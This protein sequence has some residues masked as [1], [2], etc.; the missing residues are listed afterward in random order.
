MEATADIQT[1]I[2]PSLGLTPAWTPFRSHAIQEAVWADQ[3]RFKVI[4]AGRGSGKTELAKR[5]LVQSLMFD[6][7]SK[8][9]PLR[10]YFYGAPTREHAKRVAWG[11]FIRLVPKSWLRSPD[12]ISRSEL[13]ITTRWGSKLWVLG[14]DKPERKVE[15]PQWHGCVLDESCD[16]KP[17][18]FVLNVMPAL[19]HHFG[20]CWRIGVPKRTGPSAVEYREYF[21]AACRGEKPGAKGYLW[22][23]SDI[24]SAEMLK[25]ARETLD[26][27]DYAEQFDAMFQTAGGGIYYCYDDVLNVRKCSYD[28]LLPIIVGSDFNVD[29][30]AWVI[31]QR[32]GDMLEWFDEIWLRDVSTP[33]AMDVLWA[34]WG[35]HKGGFQFFG[36]ASSSARKTSATHT[37][38][39]TIYN[40]GRFKAAGRIVR[41]PKANPA[42][43]DRF[44][45]SNAMF[46][47]AGGTRRMYVDPVCVHLRQDLRTRTYIPGTS[48]PE[49]RGRDAG[50]IADAMDYAV[51]ML[52]PIQF[53]VEQETGTVYISGGAT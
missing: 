46:G 2:G 45:S 24:V 27:K 7:I 35:H 32:R 28:P 34:K 33:D 1:G 4:P 11:D 13:S 38:Y 26:P 8:W 9:A 51:W 29:P 16:L 19:V 48:E 47:N 37:D 23:S 43:R 39:A 21:D 15:G 36:D 5:K 40:E 10:Q 17:K 12:D 49:D 50:H 44:S 20:W 18:I 42:L 22:P 31:G 3:V 6:P 25:L 30:M 52:F 53:G 41:Y 14:L